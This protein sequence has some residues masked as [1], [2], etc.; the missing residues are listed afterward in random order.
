MAEGNNEGTTP[1]I[2]PQPDVAFCP[3]H[4]SPYKDEWPKGALQMALFTV[5]KVFEADW[6]TEQFEKD[7]HGK[8]ILD[9]KRAS[10]LLVKNS[11][12][13]CKL[14]DEEMLWIQMKALGIKE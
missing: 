11:P 6:F 12:L 13:C 10:E 1:V 8:F 4:L 9:N 2:L 7:Q 5:Q 14:G 3:K